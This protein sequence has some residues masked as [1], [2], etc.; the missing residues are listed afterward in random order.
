MS[1]YRFI[2]R[3]AG[4]ISLLVI[5]GL[6]SAPPLQTAAHGVA[7]GARRELARTALTD[8]PLPAQALVSKSLGQ[9]NSAY[10]MRATGD[11]YRTSNASGT[12]QA[13]FSAQGMQLATD[14][15]QWSFAL[16]S[17][18][19]GDTHQRIDTVAPTANANRLEYA[20]ANLTEWFVNG[21]RGLEQG[22]TI[23]ARPQ[24][25]GSGLTLEL[26]LRGNA[27]VNADGSALTLLRG[28]GTPAL[29]YSGLSALDATGRELRARMETVETFHQTSLQIRV[30][31]TNA[32]YPLT[33]DPWILTAE[34][35]ASDGA[36]GDYLGW[37]LDISA[38]GGT[39]AVTT[40]NSNNAEGALYVYTKSGGSWANAT[41]TA[42][43]TT[44]DAEKNHAFGWYVAISR[45]GGTIV[46]SN[47]DNASFRG[48]IYVYT[49][50]IGGW[51][52][53]TETARLTAS[54]GA[55][56]D[57]LG[58]GL[59]ISRDGS[60][61]VGGANWANRRRGRLYVYVKPGGGWVNATETAK[62]SASDGADNDQ[63]SFALAINNDGSLIAGASPYHNSA[64][65]VVYVFARPAGGWVTS[66]ENAQLTV[67]NG[68]VDEYMGIGIAMSDDGA[69]IASGAYGKNS[70]RGMV[71][72]FTR[73]GSAWTNTT[74]TAK[75]TASDGAADD[76]FGSAVAMS[77]DGTTILSTKYGQAYIFKKPAGGWVTA[78]ETALLNDPAPDYPI[79]TDGT[80]AT[81]AFPVSGANSG[82]GAVYVFTSTP[83]DLSMLKQASIV[84]ANTHSYK[85]TITNLGAAAAEGLSI[86]DTL[87]AG[88]TIVSVTPSVATCTTSGRTVTCTRPKLKVGGTET[89]TIIANSNG[90][91]GRNCAAV[92]T[93]T[94]DPNLA[95]NKDCVKVP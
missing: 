80:G 33:I 41:Q 34:L 91:T 59:A 10:H 40:P 5:L 11:G 25:S 82:K 4:A 78:T 16:S 42:K 52:N 53:A 30:D 43:L 81:I 51:V 8:L 24:A 68:A 37:T 39:I 1:R 35:T 15:A 18:A 48:V 28:D 84:R 73:P 88:Y 93:T 89:I 20:H 60:T 49:R 64:R 90:A 79:A 85:L 14:D 67:S 13:Q 23:H 12:L 83:T 63:L 61:I 46:T 6:N 45:D 27:R 65:G 95:N 50:P 31:D 55:Q 86:A 72:V 75:L 62:L 19:Y 47:Y 36:S 9:N 71:Y 7:P 54:D 87:P 2:F 94:P 56:F 26:A 38:D 22:W 57:Y 3:L 76:Y 58:F 92:S 29:S 74:Q 17:I 70:Y 66:T 69:T 77:G 21:P 44:T 32:Q